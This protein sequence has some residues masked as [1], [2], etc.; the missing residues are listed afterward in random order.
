MFCFLHQKKTSFLDRYNR[1]MPNGYVQCKGRALCAII[2]N[3]KHVWAWYEAS[4]GIMLRGT[5]TCGR[6]IR[7]WHWPPI[8]GQRRDLRDIRRI[9]R[10]HEALQHMQHCSEMWDG[11]AWGQ[12]WRQR[13]HYCSASI[14]ELLGLISRCSHLN[15]MSE[16][17]MQQG[18]GGNINFTFHILNYPELSIHTVLMR[19]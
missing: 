9:S 16:V 12:G 6:R 8:R 3:Y 15:T 4:K 13:R 5:Q 1:H 17:K 18:M 2:D 19:R 14:C 11:A 7:E 10:I